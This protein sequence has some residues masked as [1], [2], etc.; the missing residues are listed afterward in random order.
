MSHHDFPWY[1]THESH[2]CFLK[3]INPEDPIQFMV[4]FT[5]EAAYLAQKYGARSK[6]AVHE[7]E[8]ELYSFNMCFLNNFAIAEEVLVQLDIDVL[9]LRKINFIRKLLRVSVGPPLADKADGPTD[10]D[11][12]ILALAFAIVP[13]PLLVALAIV[14]ALSLLFK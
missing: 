14:L 5:G 12:P 6:V 11:W 1:R 9:E 7:P 4:S 10:I 3:L 13:G 8:G 2:E